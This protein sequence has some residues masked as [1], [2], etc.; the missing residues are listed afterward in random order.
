MTDDLHFGTKERVFPQ[1]ILSIY[2]KYE[3]CVI[4]H[5]KALADVKDF[6]KKQ[7]DKQTG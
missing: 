7:Q 5:S 4:Y 2:L 1:G 6:A 3:S